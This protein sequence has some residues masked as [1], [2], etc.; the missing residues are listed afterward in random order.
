MAG[1]SIAGR[2]DGCPHPKG[3]IFRR[4]CALQPTRLD[5]VPR[6]VDEQGWD[7]LVEC[8]TAPT[9]EAYPAMHG[10][11]QRLAANGAM[12]HLAGPRH[13]MVWPGHAPEPHADPAHPHLAESERLSA[14]RDQAYRTT[15]SM[16]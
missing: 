9:P 8:A 7:R 3:W 4:L 6:A 12:G 14:R 15:W 10:N 1:V 2:R 13:S 5:G 16:T 11:G